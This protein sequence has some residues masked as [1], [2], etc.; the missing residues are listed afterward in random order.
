MGTD[1]HGIF[2]AKKDGV[3]IDIP[4]KWEQDRHYFLFA[5]LAGVRNGFGF[6]GVETHTPLIPINDEPR[7]LPDDFAMVD[8]CHP[9]D[10]ENFDPGKQKYTD[11]SEREYWMGD[12]SHSWLLADE[13]L[14]AQPPL[15]VTRSG[16]ITKE[17]Y[18]AWDGR[19]RPDSY[20]GGIFGKGIVTSDPESIGPYTTHVRVHWQ[21]DSAAELAY[22]IDEVRRLRD[23]YGDVR[24]V[25]GFDS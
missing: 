18:G 21:Q 12:H 11:K 8:D 1:I 2:Q 16:V 6:A 24:L 15:A 19:S 17:Q 20:S 5:W 25:F 3:W 14:A 22:F 13:I 10:Y 4:H 7:G 23:E 9:T